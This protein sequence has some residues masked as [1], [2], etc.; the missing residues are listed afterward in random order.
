MHSHDLLRGCFRP[1]QPVTEMRTIARCKKELVKGQSGCVRRMRKDLSQ[2]NIRVH[3]AV[4]D[5]RGTTGMAILR[6]I[7]K[8]GRD[9]HNLAEQALQN[10]CHKSVEQMTAHLTGNWRLDHLF[11][12]EH[13]L[14]PYDFLAGQIEAFEKEDTGAPS[15]TIGSWKIVASAGRHSGT[16]AVAVSSALSPSAASNRRGKGT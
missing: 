11:I 1:N 10:N 12:L 16:P 9:P 5:I 8:G 15:V 2:M 6:A 7:V 14:K 3:H 4:S 13:E